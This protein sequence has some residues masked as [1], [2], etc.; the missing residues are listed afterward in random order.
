MPGGIAQRD[1][2]HAQIGK[3]LHPG[4]HF[5][6]GH[7]ALHRAAK[8]QE[9]DT[10]TGVAACCAVAITCLS[11]S[12]DWLRCMRR[13][14]RLCVPLTDITRLSSSVCESMARSAPRTLG[15][16]AGVDRARSARNLAHHD[17]AV[18]Q[19]RDGLGRVQR[20]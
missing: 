13:L 3:A 12:K 9:S 14:Q 20:P 1:A 5:G 16:S 11:A 2:P 8:Q 17:L 7:I 4:Q 10:L 18:A 6:L 19:G 15:T